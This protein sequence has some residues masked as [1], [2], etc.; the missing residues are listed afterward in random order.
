MKYLK[1]VVRTEN[2]NPNIMVM[3]LAKDS[4]SSPH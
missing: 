4:L 1:T 2:S 3:K